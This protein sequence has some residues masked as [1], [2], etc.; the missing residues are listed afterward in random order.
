[1]RLYKNI[2]IAPLF[3]LGTGGDPLAKPTE[4]DEEEI[5]TN[6]EV[7]SAFS[8]KSIAASSMLDIFIC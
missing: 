3:F 8:I 5:A 4:K 2:W 7:Q 6:H 1:M